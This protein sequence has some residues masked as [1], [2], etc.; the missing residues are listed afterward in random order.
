MWKCIFGLVAQSRLVFNNQS[1]SAP[2]GSNRSWAFIQVSEQYPEIDARYTSQANG[3]TGRKQVWSKKPE[4]IITILPS[5][6]RVTA[7]PVNS[8][9]SY[10]IDCKHVSFDWGYLPLHQ[11]C[12]LFNCEVSS[13]FQEW[14]DGRESG[15]DAEKATWDRLRIE[16]RLEMHFHNVR[17]WSHPA[18]LITGHPAKVSQPKDPKDFSSSAAV[19]PILQD[20]WTLVL[21]FV[22]L[23]K[24]NVAAVAWG[25]RN[26]KCNPP[27]SKN[28]RRQFFLL[29]KDWD[30]GRGSGGRR[31]C[32][33]SLWSVRLLWIG[34]A[35]ICKQSE[36]QRGQRWA[37][38]V[39]GT[40]YEYEYYSG[41]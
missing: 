20:F 13:I 27:G 36:C 2:C 28:G 24:V 6:L 25:L 17:L 11:T 37:N 32:R 19:Q 10:S 16:S 30:L 15:E 38:S 23:S 41:S 4:F 5:L 40:E 3:R 34:R 33:W 9:L 7:F 35:G 29:Q 26:C 21:V 22:E 14:Y 18:F 31:K 8:D 39:F 1:S 12:F